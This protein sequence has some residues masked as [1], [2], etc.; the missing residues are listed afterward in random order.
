MSEVKYS[1]L[2][3]YI[4]GS[5]ELSIN[6]SMSVIWQKINHEWFNEVFSL[7][8]WGVRA[9]GHISVWPYFFEESE[10]L[11]KRNQPFEENDQCFLPWS[12]ALDIPQLHK[13]CEKCKEGIKFHIS[14]QPSFFFFILTLKNQMLRIVNFKECIEDKL[15]TSKSIS[16]LLI[17]PKLL[18]N[19]GKLIYRH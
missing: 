6:K 8:L 4:I 9:H 7:Q 12:Y 10:V 17:K 19:I 13:R 11:A 1:V 14:L 16:K 18:F 15:V 2:K 3:I 5:E